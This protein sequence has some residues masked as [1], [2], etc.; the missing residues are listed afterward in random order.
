MI[1]EPVFRTEFL[2]RRSQKQ[3]TD[4]VVPVCPARP[5][6]LNDLLPIAFFGS[7]F[8]THFFSVQV[9]FIRF[10]A[11]NKFGEYGLF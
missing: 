1:G 4:H 8:D 9:E 11:P 3:L 5:G 10:V 6:R 2:F 7:F